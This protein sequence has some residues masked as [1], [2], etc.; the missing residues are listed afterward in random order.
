M[1]FKAH[2]APSS[3]RIP[4]CIIKRI[5]TLEF[6]FIECG[7]QFFQ[8]RRADVII[9]LPMRPRIRNNAAFLKHG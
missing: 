6:T 7:L 8:P 2:H 1:K 9:P 4:T 5:R 3:N